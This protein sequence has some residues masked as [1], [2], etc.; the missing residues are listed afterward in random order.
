MCFWFSIHMGDKKLL[1]K[2]MI[3]DVYLRQLVTLALKGKNERPKGWTRK[4]E[5]QRISNL[6][7]H[8]TD[9]SKTMAVKEIIGEALNKNV[10]TPRH[11][12]KPSG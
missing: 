8:I 11:S 7:Q 4:L 5:P 9:K 12:K 2:I 10:I 3:F 1:N 6:K